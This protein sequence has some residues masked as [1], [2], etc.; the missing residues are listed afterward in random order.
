MSIFGT[1]FKDGFKAALL[2]IPSPYLWG[3]GAL[4]VVSLFVGGEVWFH[5]KVEA[6][7]QKE[8][9][10]YIAKKDKSDEELKTLIA[11][12]NADLKAALAQKVQTITR[13]VVKN[14]TV[15]QTVPDINTILSKGWVS[16]FNASAQGLVIDPV[17]ATDKTPSG[18]NAD[19]ALD[20]TN[21]NNGICQKNLAEL[22]QLQKFIQDQQAA[23]VLEN[24]KNGVK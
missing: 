14:H 21:T 2:A 5:N 6:A 22:S 20:V 18:V 15:I 12:D 19:T 17:A 24:K 23:V 3:A 13:T 8:I 16:A 9:A 4:L 7:A 1:I 10:A 11:K